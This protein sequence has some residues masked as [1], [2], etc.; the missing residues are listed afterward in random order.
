VAAVVAVVEQQVVQAGHQL[1]VQ[2]GQA[3]Q[4]QQRQQTRLQA[5]VAVRQAIQAALVGQQLYMSGS[6]FNYERT[7]L[8]TN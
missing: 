8:C 3:L 1:V 2:A 6:R 7:I 4:E 5:V